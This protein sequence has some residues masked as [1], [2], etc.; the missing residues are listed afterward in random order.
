MLWYT[1]HFVVYTCDLILA[2]IWLLG[3]CPF[4]NRVLHK[5]F[6]PRCEMNRLRDARHP[7]TLCTP[8]RSRIGPI[9]V[10]AETF[11]GLGLMPH[12]ETMCNTRFIK[13]HKPSN[14]IRSRIKS[15]VYTTKWTIYH[16]TYHIK[17]YNK[18]STNA[19]ITLMTKCLL[20]RKRSTKYNKTLRSWARRHR[21]VDW[22]TN[23]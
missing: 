3:L 1:V 10:M 17:R 19:F 21:D 13:E 14:H 2:R 12:W 11:S 18:A 20:Q 8:F 16:S 9:R 15:H 5:P 7:M 4:I 22:E 23:A 6:S